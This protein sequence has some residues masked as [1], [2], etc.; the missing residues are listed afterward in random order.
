MKLLFKKSKNQSELLIVKGESSEIFDYIKMMKGLISGDSF[1]DSQFE[2]DY[3]TEEMLKVNEMVEK[4]R[5]TITTEKECS[6]QE[7][8]L[9]EELFSESVISDSDGEKISIEDIPF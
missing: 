3:S 4:I 5:E 1:E 2:G 7:C 6:E 9:P 8:N